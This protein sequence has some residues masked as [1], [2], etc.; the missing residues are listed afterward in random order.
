MVIRI[1]L[2]E[3]AILV[4]QAFPLNPPNTW[5]WTT[6]SRPVAGLDAAEIA[7]QRRELVDPVVEV[8]VGDGDGLHRLGLGH[9]DDRR[10]V[11]AGRQVPVDAV[12]GGVQPA[13]D[14]PLPEWRVAGVQDRFPRGVPAE[15]V[16]VLLEAVREVLLAEPVKDRGISGVGLRYEALRRVVILLLA[17]VHCDL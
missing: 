9:P 6:P 1:R 4:P 3:S 7:Q 13:P 17:P 10:L 15:Q 12:V 2:P 8:P 16:G 5:E 11:G 14:E